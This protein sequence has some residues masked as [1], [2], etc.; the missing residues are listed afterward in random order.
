[1]SQSE[2]PI[3]CWKWK[4]LLLYGPYGNKKKLEDKKKRNVGAPYNI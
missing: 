3:P 1:M 2:G 4:T